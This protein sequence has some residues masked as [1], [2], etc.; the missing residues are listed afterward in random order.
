VSN[1][2]LERLLILHS[3]ERVVLAP[4]RGVTETSSLILV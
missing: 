1:T 4:D 2:S 3:F